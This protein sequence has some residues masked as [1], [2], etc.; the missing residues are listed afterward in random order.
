VIHKGYVLSFNFYY[1]FENSK[2]LYRM[3]RC[4]DSSSSK[5]IWSTE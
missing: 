2:R 4:G 1:V 5:R 3:H